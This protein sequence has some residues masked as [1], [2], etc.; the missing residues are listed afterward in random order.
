MNLLGEQCKCE[1][2]IIVCDRLGKR[3]NFCGLPVPATVT[4]NGE[5]VREIEPHKYSP[6]HQAMG[7]CKYCGRLQD[8]PI[9]EKQGDAPMSKTENWAMIG[10]TEH[11]GFYIEDWATGETICDFYY[12]GTTDPVHFK[13][14]EENARHML[15]AAKAHDGLVGALEAIADHCEN[16]AMIAQTAL[17]DIGETE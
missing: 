2:P 13:N 15:R 3:C 5:E 6:D 4:I 10:A 9:H 16:P 7:D 17:A 12:K 11:H 8:D 1:S 14:A